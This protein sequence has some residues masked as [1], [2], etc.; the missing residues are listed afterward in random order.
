MRNCQPESHFDTLSSMSAKLKKL[1][2]TID[3]K[4]CLLTFPLDNK[5]EPD[6]L[7]SSLYPKSKMT[8]AWDAD[9]DGRISEL[10]IMREEL[11]RSKKVVYAK[12]YRQRATF[13][14]QECFTNLLAYFGTSQSELKLERGAQEALDS[15]LTDSPQSTKVLKENLGLQGKML[16]STYNKAL[17]PL[18]NYLYIVGFGE[19][20]DSSFPS[21]NI[22][23]TE[24]LF[25]NLWED[26][27]SIP[28]AKAE[29]NIR[30]M[31]G[32]ENLF[33]KYALKQKKLAEKRP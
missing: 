11:S 32:E 9:S 19:V 33:Y 31:L 21:L 3:Q 8:W 7:W 23:A 22:A 17:K 25:E 27:K 20:E 29:S 4:H 13:F 14:S 28:S 24:T 12:W 6:S 26:S 10:W 15:L 16:E 30:K 18:W 1:V 2:T 5:K